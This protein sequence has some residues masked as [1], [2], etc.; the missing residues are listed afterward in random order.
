MSASVLDARHHSSM[1]GD[2]NTGGGDGISTMLAAPSH[3]HRNHYTISPSSTPTPREPYCSDI[4]TVVS[5]YGQIDSCSTPEFL[6]RLLP[7]IAQRLKIAKKQGKV[8]Y[9]I[10][11]LPKLYESYCLILI[12]T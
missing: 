9:R 5:P 3:T 6:I 11:I 8:D 10:K 7:L 2:G 12:L 4:E 1:G